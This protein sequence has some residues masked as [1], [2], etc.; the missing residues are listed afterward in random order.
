ML[1]FGFYNIWGLVRDLMQIAFLHPLLSA[2]K[3]KE[4]TETGPLGPRP[5]TFSG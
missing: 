3:D 4:A 1:D 5:V 2:G